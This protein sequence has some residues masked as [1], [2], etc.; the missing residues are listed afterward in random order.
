M[1]RH[2]LVESNLPG[3]TP[4]QAFALVYLDADRLHRFHAAANGD[5][6]AAVPPWAGGAREVRFRQR[7]AAPAALTR[8]IGADSIVVVDRQAA[9]RLPGGGGFEVASAPAPQM[10]GGGA[11]SVK[12]R[13]T[14]GP[15]PGGGTAVAV[16]VACAAAGPWGLVGA[17]EAFMADSAAKSAAEFWSW[18]AGEVAQ[19]HATGALAAAAHAAAAAAAGWA[20][21]EEQRELD[22]LE[23]AEQFEA[24]AEAAAAARGSG[25]A[26]SAGDELFYEPSAELDSEGLPSPFDAPVA[27]TAPAA[28]PG[29]APP[30]GAPSWG[31]WLS[32]PTR[33]AAPS[34]LAALP[35]EASLEAVAALLGRLAAAGERTAALIAAL[36][37]RVARA[38]AARA[39]ER[40]ADASP[41]PLAPLSWSAWL[42]APPASPRAALFAL[43]AAFVGGL[44]V[45][46]AATRAR[47]RGAGA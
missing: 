36:E 26:G 4:E 18:M 42:A 39:A 41:A 25:G 44:A 32:A 15:A 2:V 30:P 28:G 13:I 46:L 21:E 5:A 34:S 38:E 40:A 12:A 9:K 1:V 8:L 3:V 14:L 23:A 37:A 7:V 45:G 19:L 33:T 27:P 6:A 22:E 29:W 17:I 10:L 31:E 11:S 35:E 24:V 20:G 47:S 43:G 16:A